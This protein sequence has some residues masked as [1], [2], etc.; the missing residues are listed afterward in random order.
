M[1]KFFNK[2]FS[3]DAVEGPVNAKEE[4]Q[5]ESEALAAPKE[6][7]D[8]PAQAVDVPFQPIDVVTLNQNIPGNFNYYSATWK[9]LQTYLANRIDV[10]H[11]QNENAKL[12]L[13]RT[14]II[15][16]QLKEIKLLLKHTNQLAGVSGDSFS[17]ALPTKTSLSSKLAD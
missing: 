16:G 15:R 9:Y 6:A 3:L 7:V 10:L 1:R 13:E 8:V 17:S 2:F 11:R 14:Q 5:L 12:P 4:C